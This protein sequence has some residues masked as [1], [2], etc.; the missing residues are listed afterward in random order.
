MAGLV[1]L[2]MLVVMVDGGGG[3]I[4]EAAA[5]PE[6]VEAAVPIR[7]A[8]DRR[9]DCIAHFESRNDPL[10]RNR[11]SGASGLLQFL[12]STW[13]TTPQGRAGLSIWDA[14]A[15][16]AAGRYMINAGRIREW[17]VVRMGLC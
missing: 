15:Q 10:A 16:R 3:A 6:I 7:D 11:S 2:A 1:G 4:E 9:L 14:A 13:R 8:I 12:P 5:E 17:S